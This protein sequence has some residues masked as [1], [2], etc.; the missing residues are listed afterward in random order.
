MSDEFSKMSIFIAE[1][2]VGG[3]D[4]LV[5]DR[6]RKPPEAR[7]RGTQEECECV[8]RA[9]NVLA[10]QQYGVSIAAENK[11]RFDHLMRWDREREEKMR[12]LEE[13]L[14]AYRR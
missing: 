10:R 13:R 8:A 6:S 1:P 4:W 7:F 5:T 2:G 12:V 3:E 11:K 14:R 9:L